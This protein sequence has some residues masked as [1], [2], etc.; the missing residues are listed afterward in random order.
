MLVKLYDKKTDKNKRVSKTLWHLNI[1]LLYFYKLNEDLVGGGW[2][3]SVGGSWRKTVGGERR[4]WEVV[5]GGG[6]KIKQKKVEFQDKWSTK[7]WYMILLNNVNIN[8]TNVRN[9]I[10]KK[11]YELKLFISL[12]IEI[13]ILSL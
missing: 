13:K 3:E 2:R 4:W 7:F 11:K 10:E 8:L 9:S 6:R 5:E 1:I 12:N